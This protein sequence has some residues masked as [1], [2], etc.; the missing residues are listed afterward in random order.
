MENSNVRQFFFKLQKENTLKMVTLLHSSLIDT[1]QTFL[2]PSFLLLASRLYREKLKS[3]RREL[4][5]ARDHRAHHMEKALPKRWGGKSFPRA[6][7]HQ[8]PFWS[9][10]W[11]IDSV[12]M[13]PCEVCYCACHYTRGHEAWRRTRSLPK[14]VQLDSQQ[15][16]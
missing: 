11:T 16:H 14:V 4:G 9:D 2:L 7:W 8:A 1:L 12:P 13:S 3:I 6:S 15:W 10:T 5:V